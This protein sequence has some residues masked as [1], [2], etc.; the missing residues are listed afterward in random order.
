M[1]KWSLKSV[2]INGGFLTGFSAEL[3]PGLTCVIGPRGSGKSTFV[4]ALRFGISGSSGASKSRLELIQATLVPPTLITLKTVSPGSGEGY[5]IRRTYKQPAT[6][7]TSDGRSI[8][9]VDLDRGTFLPLDGYSSSEI[10]SIADESVGA[11]RRSLLDE[12]RGEELQQVNLKVAEHRR[13]LE[14]NADRVRATRRLIAD[15]T[16]QIEELGDVSAKLAALPGAQEEVASSDLRRTTLQK[17]ANERE[18]RNLST[19]D[20]LLETYRSGLQAIVRQGQAKSF[21]ALPV[22]GSANIDL[23]NAAKEA[24]AA[25]V[26]AAEGL[27]ERAM[28]SIANAQYRLK[29]IEEELNRAHI[30]QGA[31]HAKLAEANLVASQAVKER[32]DLEQKLDQL[33]ELESERVTSRSELDRLLQERKSLKGNYLLE[34][35]RVSAVRE[36]VASELQREAGGK[37]RIRVIR[38]ADNLHYQ[39]LLTDGLRG[40][41]VRNQDDILA[42]LL[43]LR[44]EELAQLIQDNDLDTFENLTSFGAE[45]SRKILDAFRE[46]IDPLELDIAHVEDRIRIELNVSTTSEPNFKDASELSRGQKCTALLPLLLARRETPLVIDQPEDNLDNHFI[47]ETVVE[48]VRRL[49]GRRQMIFITHNANIPVLAEADLVI[50]LNSDGR[51]GYVEKAGTLDDCRDEIVDLLEGGSEAF[52]LRRQRYEQT[53]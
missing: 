30:I 26:G 20:Q 2:D 9:T 8:T 35:E 52:E 10:E 21:D 16:E 31:E 32:A 18:L 36:S 1:S 46:N 3:P 39:Q 6:L 53:R 50:V 34:R 49:K 28:S 25:A 7:L 43:R 45:R 44:P 12:L 4:E 42:T 23:M 11:K 51:R 22:E 15:L 40:A 48:T 33:R 14:A 38:N 5:T 13:A 27:L 41:R 47:Y 37:V 17:Q 29:E 19:A 24:V